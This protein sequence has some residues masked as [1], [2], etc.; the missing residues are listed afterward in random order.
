MLLMVMTAG[1][2]GCRRRRRRRRCRTTMDVRH[3]AKAPGPL[4]V[5]RG[6][7]EF[8]ACRTARKC[9]GTWTLMAAGGGRTG[10]SSHSSQ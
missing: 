2:G 7:L 8:S 10:F 1:A 6:I 3:R 5:D 9:A 4:P